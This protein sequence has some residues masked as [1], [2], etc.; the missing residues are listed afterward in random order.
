MNINDTDLIDD[1][2]SGDS[3]DPL[4]W[5]RNGTIIDP[6]DSWLDTSTDKGEIENRNIKLKYPDITETHLCI[7]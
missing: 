4:P 2:T 7:K 5:D 6:D 1:V 3:E